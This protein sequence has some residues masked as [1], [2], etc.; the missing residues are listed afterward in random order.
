MSRELRV[1]S[2]SL[3]EPE[4]VFRER[5]AHLS[6]DEHRRAEAFTREEPR[7]RFIVARSQLRKLLGDLLGIAPAEVAFRYGPAGKPALTNDPSVHFNLAHSADVAV[8]VIAKHP[9]G[10]DLE[11][12]RPMKNA[13]GLAE[14]WFHPEEQRRIATAVD[15]L[16]SFFQ[17][18][19]RKEAVLKLVG[20]GVGESLPRVLT[21]GDPA[22]GQATALPPNGLGLTSCR[23]E[24]LAV[25]PAFAASI[26]VPEVG[27]FG[28]PA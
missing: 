16:D 28:R 15:P 6:E 2:W 18:W 5:L 21:P 13:P 20:V 23:V 4:G 22:G 1:G 8:C 26:A 9:V 17:T 7:R 14:R 11:R 27:D 25:D 12:R 3:D 19:T 10:V 24:P